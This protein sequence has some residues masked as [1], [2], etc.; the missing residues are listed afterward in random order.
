VQSAA[1]EYK[2][3]DV[4]NYAYELAKAFNEFYNHCQ[5][6]K[7]EPEVRDARVRLVAAAREALRNALTILGIDA[8]E[9][10]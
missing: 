3:L 7:A 4:T 2:T 6:L 1:E 5:V 10:M 9:V 8:P